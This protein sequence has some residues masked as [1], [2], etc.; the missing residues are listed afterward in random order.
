MSVAD[1]NNLCKGAKFN[2]L[3]FGDITSNDNEIY[4]KGKKVNLQQGDIIGKGSLGIVRLYTF[5]V[6]DET[7]RLAYKSNLDTIDEEIELDELII[8]KKYGNALTCDGLI[9]MLKYEN[10]VLMPLANGDMTHFIGK[11]EFNQALEVAYRISLQI[12]CLVDK[13]YNYYDIKPHNVLYFCRKHG[14]IDIVL[15][16]IGSIIDDDDEYTCTYPPPDFYEGFIT[17]FNDEGRTYTYMML[18]MIILFT[19][20]L[21]FPLFNNNKQQYMVMFKKRMDQLVRI[22]TKR[23]LP[24][25]HPILKMIDSLSKTLNIHKLPPFDL[26]CR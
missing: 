23:G 4:Y 18:H 1:L 5:K 12:K 16:D 7:F 14:E 9:V 22:F 15:G 17:E 6:G 10:G 24:S 13:G 25:D 26:F 2:L 20:G 11:L 8:L 3:D 21:D 19:L